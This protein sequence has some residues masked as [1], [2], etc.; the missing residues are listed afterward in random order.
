MS[1]NDDFYSSS[2]DSNVNDDFIKKKLKEVNNFDSDN[3]SSDL[4]NGKYTHNNN[5]AELQE[6]MEEIE[7]GKLIEV[8]KKLEFDERLKIKR[9]K[10]INKNKIQTKL[11]SVN[12]N[13][14]KFEPKEFSALMKPKSKSKNIQKAF[15]RDPRFD[16][17]SG[18]F[19]PE[20]HEKRYGFVK[21]E[22]KNYLE[23]I[24]KLKKD[25]KISNDNDY[26]LYKKQMNFV[27]GWLKKTEYSENKNNINKEIKTENKKRAESGKNPIYLKKNQ[28]KHIAAETYKEKR[29]QEDNKKF[30]KR[31]KHRE[32]I[33][34]RKDERFSRALNE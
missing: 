5:Y 19:K 33:Q 15:R 21:E 3:E 25:K 12:Q 9:N 16:D 10:K 18:Q 26:D 17:L 24:Q 13:K 27:K 14:E 1:D 11:E 20:L 29:N 6:N 22:T 28:L 4:K 8:Q 23:K 34:T 32:M 31:K 2:G 7:F 30:L